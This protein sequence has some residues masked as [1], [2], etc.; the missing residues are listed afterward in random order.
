MRKVL[1]VNT[2]IERAPYPVPP[3]GL[4]LL[5]AGLEDRY[6]VHIYDG[7]F[8]EGRNLVAEVLRF[9]PDYIGFSIRNI[10]DVVVDRNVFYVDGILE[11]FILP[12]KAV[13]PAPLILGGSGFS[14]FPE[15]LMLASGADYGII[16]EAEDSFP[17]LL[18][19]LENK[20]DPS[21]IA[22]LVIAGKRKIQSG[23]QISHQGQGLYR[24]SEIDWHIDFQPYLSRGVYSIQTKRGCSHG[25]IYCTY[26]LIEGKRF[27]MRRAEEIADEMEQAHQRIG[28]VTFEFVDSTFNDPKNHAEAICREI[29]RRKM[30]VSLRTMGMNPRHC[31]EALF[32]LMMKAGFSQI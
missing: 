7:V 26:P 2:N 5:A 23:F 31:S 22:N 30:K 17:A 25:C 11:K 32:E 27:R 9:L 20:L 15:E 13:T 19:C 4:C 6:E 29:I 16:G 14:I 21:G 12:V 10:D 24:F 28:A 1:L 8:D 18:N 3:L